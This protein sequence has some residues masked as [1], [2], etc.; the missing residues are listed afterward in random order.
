MSFFKFTAFPIFLYI[1]AVLAEAKVLT[2]GSIYQPLPP[3]VS[4]HIKKPLNM[5]PDCN[6]SDTD[7]SFLLYDK[8]KNYYRLTA[9]K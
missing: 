6:I 2:T 3:P 8:L 7:A 5:A 9:R 4:F 1:I